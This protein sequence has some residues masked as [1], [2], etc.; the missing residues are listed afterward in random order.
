MSGYQVNPWKR[1]GKDRLYV[2]GPDG[3]Q[4]GWV[5]L[6]TNTRR[7][8]NPANEAAFDAAIRGWFADTAPPA[9]HDLALNR[10][11]VGARERALLEEAALN[12]SKV[13]TFV[14]RVTDQK[15]VERNW[16][17]GAR[18]EET[19]GTRLERLRPG[20]WHVL[21]SIPVGSNS[22]DIDHVLI[23]PGGVITVN[24]KNHPGHRIWV[25]SRSI[26]IDGHPTDYLY[27]SRREAERAEKL[28]FAV[29][30]LPV[31]VTPALVFAYGEMHVKQRPPDVLVMG[32]LN[33]PT[34]FRRRPATLNPK[35]VAV[36]FDAARRC[37]TWTRACRCD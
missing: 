12:R 5:D 7:V 30:G 11:G 9:W 27:K 19:V 8:N 10:P 21:H 4:I 13:A 26:R 20:G 34:D 31:P 23:G 18:G 1:Y 17:V 16:R 35:E 32:S 36:L 24:T 3:S 37:T 28:L 6:Q 22:C 29:T 25:A 33:V 2:N 15:T 14:A